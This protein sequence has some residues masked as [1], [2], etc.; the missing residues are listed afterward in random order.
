M[1]TTFLIITSARLVTRHNL[2]YILSVVRQSRY[3]VLSAK[4]ALR[5]QPV[6]KLSGACHYYLQMLQGDVVESLGFIVGVD[7]LQATVE[8]VGKLVYV[9]RLLGKLNEPL[10]AAL[11][12]L[13]H[14][15]RCSRVFLHLGTRL[16]AGVSQSLLGVVLYKFLA[17]GIDEVF[18]TTGNDK[19]IGAN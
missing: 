8:N 17:E 5:A 6:V 7:V 3:L 4:L 9:G 16:L 19:L 18:G 2:L 13:I 10:V 15:Y 12:V 14:K 11:G 1:Y